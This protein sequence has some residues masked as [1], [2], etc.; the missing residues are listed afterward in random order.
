MFLLPIRFIEKTFE[1][2]FH[3]KVLLF[4]PPYFFHVPTLNFP[5]LFVVFAQKLDRGFRKMN[6][7]SRNEI[8]FGEKNYA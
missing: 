3:I 5:Y 2:I 8:S 4:F 1:I 7:V 6:L